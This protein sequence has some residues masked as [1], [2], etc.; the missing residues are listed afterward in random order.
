MRLTGSCPKVTSRSG[1]QTWP[2]IFS[3]SRLVSI[4][5]EQVAERRAAMLSAQGSDISTEPTVMLPPM[6]DEDD[7]PTEPRI[8]RIRL[9]PLPV[10][11]NHNGVKNRDGV[12]DI[13]DQITT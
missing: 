5:D 12:D 7:D 11:G 6:P 1:W 10:A 13:G 8:Q 4:N 9:K 3:R 2:P